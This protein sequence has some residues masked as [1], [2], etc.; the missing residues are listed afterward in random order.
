MSSTLIV[1]LIIGTIA[2]LIFA[3]QFS[4]KANRPHGI[5]RFFAFESILILLLLNIP[6]WFQN[7]LAW[8]QLISWI[9]LI[10]SV[11]F[12]FTGF[13]LLRIVGKPQNGDIENT[14]KLVTTGLYKYIRHPLYSSLLLLGTGI[15]LK[16]ITSVS[17]VFAI[18]NAAA[19][20]LTARYEEKEMIDK[21][22]DEYKTYMQKT[23]MF[24]PYIF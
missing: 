23:R 2:N 1:I 10:F 6:A 24:L 14:S 15:F 17:A 12:A 18:L 9:L 21:F 19:L 5:P 8:N 3:W 11:V 22:G 4:L 16:D 7:P 13:F 20:F